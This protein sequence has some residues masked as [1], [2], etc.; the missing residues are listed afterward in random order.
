[1]VRLAA[2]SLPH[3]APPTTRH[4][5]VPTGKFMGITT[6]FNPGRHANKVDNFRKFR[7][8]VAAQ[9]L[10]M[11]C[12]EL[13]FGEEADFQLVAAENIASREAVVDDDR[14]PLI[15][16]RS[17]PSTPIGSQPQAPDCD[18]LIQRRTPAGNTLWQK[19]RLLN[20]ALENLP[21]T[22][23]KVMWLDSDLIFLNDDWVIETS[24][25][26]DRFPVVQPFGWMTYLSAGDDG[27]DMAE[28]LATLPL[29]QGVGAVYHSAGLG[30]QSFP[31]MCFRS[32]FLLGWWNW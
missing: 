6:F 2:T 15:S 19:E 12:V 18:I 11:L 14:Q 16:G 4:A 32:N 8:S 21:H 26:L 27:S 23:T 9:G 25:M 20:I 31:D 10:Q 29:G 30:L 5:R 22:V 24:E 17:G 28:T 3:Q 13:V 1:M 7:A